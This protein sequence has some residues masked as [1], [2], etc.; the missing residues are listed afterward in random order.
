MQ[1][2]ERV[3]QRVESGAMG[4]RDRGQ[5]RLQGVELQVDAAGVAVLEQAFGQAQRASISPTGEPTSRQCR[6]A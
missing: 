2:R 4:Q 6:S 5:V 3:P 1:L